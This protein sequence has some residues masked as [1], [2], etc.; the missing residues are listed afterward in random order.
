MDYATCKATCE[1]LGAE[2]LCVPDQSVNSYIASYIE[3]RGV[4]DYEN[5]WLGLNDIVEEGNYEWES[6]SCSSSFVFW[7]KGKP[8][9]HDGIENC[10]EVGWYVPAFNVS[11]YDRW[12]DKKCDDKSICGC[13]RPARPCACQNWECE[14]M[15]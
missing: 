8:D 14:N 5:V 15:L 13:Q 2:M 11:D 6:S 7:A 9:N 3:G 10:V 12:N 4:E 1:S